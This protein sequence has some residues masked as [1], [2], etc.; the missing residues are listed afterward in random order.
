V[1][2]DGAYAVD[3]SSYALAAKGASSR[4]APSAASQRDFCGAPGINVVKVTAGFGA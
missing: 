3:W 4:A 2:D 1:L